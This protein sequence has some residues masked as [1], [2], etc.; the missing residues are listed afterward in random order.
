MKPFIWV[1]LLQTTV[2][3]LATAQGIVNETTSSLSNSTI[4][5]RLNPAAV[6]NLD[7]ND[8]VTWTVPNTAS[9]DFRADNG[10]VLSFSLSAASGKL[11][12]NYNKAVYT[13]MISSLG[14]RVVAE[15]ISTQT[16]NGDNVGGVPIT[17]SISGLPTGGHTLLTWHN[18]WDKLN[19]TA[20]VTVMVDGKDAANSIK[21]SVRID[22]IWGAAASYINFTATAGKAVEVVYNSDKSGDGRVFLNGFEIDT[23]SMQNQISFPSPR[24]NDERVE[25]IG[26]EVDASWRAVK[27]E[28]AVYNVYLGM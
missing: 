1:G 5:I 23:P 8:F 18:A 22:N 11:N 15:G 7:D 27:T 19:D 14:E 10:T 28:G 9:A 17:L 13:R 25:V 26:N 12:G 3:A 21:Q 16:D 24:H 6:R 4:R 20:S 2:V